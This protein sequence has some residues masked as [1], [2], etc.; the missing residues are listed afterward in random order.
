ML[1]STPSQ[2]AWWS[3]QLELLLTWLYSQVPNN[4]P[5]LIN[6]SIFSNPWTLLEPPV[7]YFK[8]VD[9]FTNPWFHSISLLVPFT[10]N[11]QGKL[12][13]F[14]ICF[15]SMPYDNLFLFFPSFYNQFRSPSPFIK[16]KNFF[17]PPC[18]L[19]PPPFILHLR[20]GICW[21][22]DQQYFI[23]LVHVFL[24]IIF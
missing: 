16:V 19:V 11:I 12:E 10:P 22:F 7:Y 23:W 24:K 15:N 13:C 18:L 8:E 6:F 20:V 3:Y 5:P 17:Q 1:F 4:A 9:F 21:S 2:R 14:C